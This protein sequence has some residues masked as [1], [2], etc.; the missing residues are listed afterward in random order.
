[1][2]ITSLV[3]YHICLLDVMNDNLQSHNSNLV[4]IFPADPDQ[5]SSIIHFFNLNFWDNVNWVKVKVSVFRSQPWQW[6]HWR[7][8]LSIQAPDRGLGAVTTLPT[9]YNLIINSIL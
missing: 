2:I 6:C 1:M 9:F 8:A 3:P 5:A 4:L 7:P